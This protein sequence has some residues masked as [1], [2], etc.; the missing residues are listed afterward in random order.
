LPIT[1]LARAR[2]NLCWGENRVA[3]VLCPL[4]LG[5]R[6]GYRKENDYERKGKTDSCHKGSLEKTISSD[7]G[8]RVPEKKE[9]GG[10]KPMEM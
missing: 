6:V 1:E 5:G 7:E 10:E 4:N 2:I 9:R 3:S 8:K